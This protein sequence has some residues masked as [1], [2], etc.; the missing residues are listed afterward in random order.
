MR[1]FFTP[2]IRAP[3]CRGRAGPLGAAYFIATLV[4]PLLITHG[5]VFRLL[6]R[7]DPAAAGR[8]GE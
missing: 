4:V 1:I 5:L 8:N 7:A 2:S 6:L 3:R